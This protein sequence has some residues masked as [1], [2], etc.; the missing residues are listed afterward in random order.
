MFT[1]SLQ[2]IRLSFQKNIKTKLYFNIHALY[3][4]VI[5]YRET[6][7]S[8]VYLLVGLM[9]IKIT[10]FLERVIWLSN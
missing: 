1:Y 4:N 8:I 6:F 5:G 9:I 10:A 7:S 2:S 3:K